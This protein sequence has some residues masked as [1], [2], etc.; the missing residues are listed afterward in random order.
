MLD[1]LVD[2]D[3][4]KLTKPEDMPVLDRWLL[5]KLNELIEKAEQSYCDY[6]FH[7]ITHAV[8]DFCVNTLSSFYL[9]IVKDRLYCEGAEQRLPAAARRPP[10][11]SRST[12]FPSS[13]R[14]S[15]LSPATRSGSPCRTPAMTTRATWSSMR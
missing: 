4:E 1:N 6:E 7:I 14:R 13:S 11:T 12:R 15:S 8:N 3:P 2:F 9:D 10:C 5:T